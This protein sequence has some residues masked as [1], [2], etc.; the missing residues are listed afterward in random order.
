MKKSTSDWR[1]WLAVSA[2]VLPLSLASLAATAGV[3]DLG[4]T[5]SGS[6]VWGAG[7]GS[8]CTDLSLTGTTAVSGLNSYFGAS[9]T[10]AFTF[11]AQ[12]N[13]T[14]GWGGAS[15]TGMAPSGGWQ[16]TDG[17]GDSL[18]GSLDGGLT[19]SSRSTSLAWFYFGVTGGTGTFSNASG[20]VGG[21]LGNLSSDGFFYESGRLLV[22]SPAPQSAPEPGTWALFAAALAAVGWTACRRRLARS[23]TAG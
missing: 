17:S 12:L 18:Y 6:A 20:G 16:L 22:D 8:S 23:R 15:A 7:C 14:Q 21:S 19:G 4:F 10:P 5:T 9:G 11:S 2:A 13:I 1:H 3:V